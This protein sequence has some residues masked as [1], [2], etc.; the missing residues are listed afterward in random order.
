MSVSFL[1]RRDFRGV[2]K[3]DAADS[4]A[5]RRMK[6]RGV[7]CH[8]NVFWPTSFIYLYKRQYGEKWRQE[9]KYAATFLQNPLNF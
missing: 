3:R 4:G 8:G 6:A 1:F 2:L 5:C 9:E 7:E